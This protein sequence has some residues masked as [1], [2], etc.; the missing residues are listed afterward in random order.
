MTIGMLHINDSI[1]MIELFSFIVEGFI[2]HKTQTINRL[3][4]RI[5]LTLVKLSYNGL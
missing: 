3:D 1:V 5:V 4:K 2:V